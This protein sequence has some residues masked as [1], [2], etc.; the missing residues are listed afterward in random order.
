VEL[1]SPADAKPLV[2]D[3]Y[4]AWRKRASGEIRRREYRWDFDLGIRDTAWGKP[5]KGWVAVHRAEAGRVDGYVRWKAEDKWEQNVPRG[6]VT[7]DELHALDDAAYEALWRFLAEIDLVAKVRAEFRRVA[8]RL[9][10]V[11]TDARQAQVSDVVDGLWARLLDVPSALA[12]R[13]YEREDRLVVDVVDP[14]AAGGRLR[15]RVDGGP[16][17]ATATA[18]TESADLT[19][20]VGALGAAYLGGSRLRDATSATGGADEH[21]TGALA[22]A[23]ALF[24]TADEPWCSTFF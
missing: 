15:V 18:T 20:S 5:W 17:G 10:W 9:P 24:R 16:D 11:L 21:T 23:D 13:R 4:E 6:I 19:V 22:R 8:E 14:E 2:I 3:V 12:A 1:L 7:V